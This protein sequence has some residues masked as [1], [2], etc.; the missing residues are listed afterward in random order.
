[1]LILKNWVQIHLKWSKF[2]QNTLFGRD[3]LNK[4]AKAEIESLKNIKDIFQRWSSIK[5]TW[6]KQGFRELY[7]VITS[8]YTTTARGYG[9]CN[10]FAY[11]AIKILGSVFQYNNRQ[12]DNL[13]MLYILGTSKD[14]SGHAVSIWKS[15]IDYI[16]TSNDN[17]RIYT[18]DELLNYINNKSY[19]DYLILISEKLKII[20]CIKYDNNLK[21]IL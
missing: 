15:D 5:V 4:S 18:Y 10:C 12:Y 11:L 21:D 16:V 14:K 9:D 19:A 13:G 3:K 1:M 6:K 7:D 8:E 2:Y 17:I 20:N